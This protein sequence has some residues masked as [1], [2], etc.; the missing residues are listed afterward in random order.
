MN[1]KGITEKTAC[2]IKMNRAKCKPD[3]ARKCEIPHVLNCSLVDSSSSFIHARLPKKSEE[4]NLNPLGESLHARLFNNLF[5]WVHIHRR[6][7]HVG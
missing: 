3:R 1:G 2:Q 7:D 4:K 6:K 5:F